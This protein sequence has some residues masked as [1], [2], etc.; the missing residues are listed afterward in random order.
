VPKIVA[1]DPDTGK[2][3]YDL[4]YRRKRLDWSYAPE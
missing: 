4:D 3:A 1:L 2:A